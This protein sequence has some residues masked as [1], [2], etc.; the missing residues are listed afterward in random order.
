M[1]RVASAGSTAARARA[2][3]LTRPA[4]NDEPLAAFVASAPDAAEETRKT[5]TLELTT[6]TFALELALELALGCAPL[7]LGP[8]ALELGGVFARSPAIAGR[9]FRAKRTAANLAYPI[10]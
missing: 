5:S 2:K 9:R 8:R 1:F 10:P 4:N 6:P 7:E 3:A